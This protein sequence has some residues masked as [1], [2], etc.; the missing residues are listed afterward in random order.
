MEPAVAPHN[1]VPQMPVEDTSVQTTVD[2]LS[3]SQLTDSKVSP[4]QNLADVTLAHSTLV[5]GAV[6][7]N[8]TSE[9]LEQIN[10]YSDES[11][12]DSTD[13]L[14]QVTNVIE[15]SDVRPT[16]RTYEALRSLV[17]RYG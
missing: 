17:E 14:D 5:A 1:Q 3:V 12:T 8:S 4:I 16:D 11:L 15:L 2:K 6:T 13:A 9:V 10:H 7:T